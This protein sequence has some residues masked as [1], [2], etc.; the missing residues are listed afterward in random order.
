MN[1]VKPI[2][3]IYS[4]EN[5]KVSQIAFKLGTLIFFVVTFFLLLIVCTISTYGFVTYSMQT[6]NL[7]YQMA[8]VKQ[9]LTALKIE[10]ERFKSYLTFIEQTDPVTLSY[11]Y[12]AQE[13]VSD[14][15]ITDEV[16][17][18]NET[19]PPL[20]NAPKSEVVMVIPEIVHDEGLIKLE[21][22]KVDLNAE[23]N[24]INIYFNLRNTKKIPKIVGDA[25]FTLI[26]NDTNEEIPFTK[27]KPTSFDFSN[28][29]ETHARLTPQNKRVT[30]ED[31]VLIKLIVDS[32]E[33]YSEIIPIK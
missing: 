22:A 5:G 6:Y 7:N 1:K 31:L 11:L 30:S 23:E 19:P 32:K 2:L 33:V 21:N 3:L 13:V 27:L 8:E 26:K 4:R 25:T 15:I 24:I 28:L 10:R 20:E 17:E 14:D 18:L 29:R 9:E 12:D 16:A